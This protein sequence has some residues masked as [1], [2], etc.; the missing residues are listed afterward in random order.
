MNLLFCLFASLILISTTSIHMKSTPLKPGAIK[1]EKKLTFID[2]EDGFY[3]RVVTQKVKS[4]LYASLDVGNKRVVLFDQNGKIIRSFGKEGNGPGEISRPQNIRG[5]D[6]YL[7]VLDN[8]RTSIF[9]YAG[10]YVNSIKER[11]WPEVTNT[12]ITYDFSNRPNS[13]VLKKVYDIE[14]NLLSEVAND[15]YEEPKE[16]TN[17]FDEKRIKEMLTRP[18]GQTSYRDG[19]L[20]IRRGA[21]QIEYITSTSKTIITRDF[22][23]IKSTQSPIPVRVAGKRTKEIDDNIKKM[24]AAAEAIT[25]GYL[26]D[27]SYIIGTYKDYIFVKPTSEDNTDIIIDVISPDF[28]L[29][30]QIKMSGDELRSFSL[31]DNTLMVNR[32]NE[33]DGPYSEAYEFT[34]D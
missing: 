23:R 28:Q 9:D 16:Q 7:Y 12:K 31:S 14:G 25:G 5:N 27:I 32:S 33:E 15:E 26:S 34:L 3:D 24:N 1:L 22:D 2:N 8:G 30:D 11:G 10:K 4:D 21:Y 29:Y 13:K 20:Q 17:F 19:F 18:Y 6:T